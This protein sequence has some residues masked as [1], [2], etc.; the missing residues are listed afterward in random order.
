MDVSQAENLINA[1]FDHFLTH[2]PQDSRARIRE[3]KDKIFD[4]SQFENNPHQIV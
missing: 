3:F 1:K 2:V 4:C